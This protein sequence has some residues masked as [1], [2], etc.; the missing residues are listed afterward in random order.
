MNGLFPDEPDEPPHKDDGYV[1]PRSERRIEPGGDGSANPAVD[2]IR[3]K[4]DALYGAEPNARKELREAAE[5]DPRSKHQKFM[6]EL[7]TSGKSLS[8]IQTA[9]HRYYIGLSDQEK[10]EVWQEFYAANSRSPSPQTHLLQQR[11]AGVRPH[12]SFPQPAQTPEAHQQ[13]H[14]M[15]VPQARPGVT[16]PAIAHSRVVV[17]EHEPLPPRPADRRSTA[18]IRKQ[19]LKHVRASNSA[20]I[21]AKQHLQSLAFGL[22]LGALVTVIFLFGFFN[23]VIIAP[24]IRPSSR[25]EATPIIL[26]Q[27]SLA[28]NN[29]P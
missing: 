24:Y 4:I 15:A 18:T 17:A 9:W 1:L 19:V 10:R 27:S 23:E 29:T 5:A 20:Q 7:S 14:L 22:G 25:S 12:H 8:E 16:T 13:P 2:L 11:S 6:Y 21:K 28:P 26:S 3:R